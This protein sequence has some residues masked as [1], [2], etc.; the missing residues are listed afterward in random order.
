MI[1][2]KPS[3]KVIAARRSFIKA[4]ETFLRSIEGESAFSDTNVQSIE[5][6]KVKAKFSKVRDVFKENERSV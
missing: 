3:C 6:L 4:L 2:S 5:V 1:R